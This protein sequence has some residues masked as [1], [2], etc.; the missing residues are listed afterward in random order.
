MEEV[1]VRLPAASPQTYLRYVE[2]WREVERFVTE[3][4]AREAA[5]A[6]AGGPVRAM[7]VQM[8]APSQITEVE[9]QVHAAVR[10][11]VAEVAP[12]VRGDLAMWR[13]AMAYGE[14]RREWLA[15]LAEGGEAVPELPP[16]VERLREQVLAAIRRRLSRVKPMLQVLPA[17][18]PG[19]F[20]LVGEMDL[21]NAEAVGT[22]L[23]SEL[24]LGYRLSIDLSGVSFMDSTGL[25]LLI[26]LARRAQ[27]LGLAPVVILSPSRAVK[28]VVDVAIPAGIP[29]VEVRTEGGSTPPG[30]RSLFL[31]CL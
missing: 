11:G 17:E 18:E 31:Y 3:D 24:A 19:A 27:A 28:H 21:T 15:R 16:D 20:Q 26:T 2:W 5:A 13:L 1:R 30:P 23:E 14:R 7:A 25:R 29:G 8:V 10:S 4:P 6:A 22:V 12:D 9:E